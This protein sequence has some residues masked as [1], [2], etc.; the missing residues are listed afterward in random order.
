M[1]YS[2]TSDF[3][4]FLPN[5]EEDRQKLLNKFNDW[6]PDEMGNPALSGD[7]EM[8]EIYVDTWDNNKKIRFSG[9]IDG[10]YIGG[11]IPLYANDQLKKFVRNLGDAVGVST[12]DGSS[13]IFLEK[14]E[15]AEIR[16]KTADGQGR[17]NLGKKYAGKDVEVVV[18]A[19][20]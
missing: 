6:T 15:I 12:F 13:G 18:I 4:I 10:L 8:D 19:N 17:I 9:T 11:T 2:P 7:F 20:E 1:V 5:D 14:E 3:E 16:D